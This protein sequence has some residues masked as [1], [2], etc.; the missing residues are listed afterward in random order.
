[1]SAAGGAARVGDPAGEADVAV[2]PAEARRELLT[3]LRRRPGWTA[4]AATAL[5]AS[6]VAAIPQATLLAGALDG[7]FLRGRDLA[8]LSVPLVLLLAVVALRAVAEGAGAHA[9]ARAAS[10]VTT[11]LRAELTEGLLALG[12]AYLE[13]RRTGELGNDVLEGTERVGPVVARFLPQ[14]IVCAV[15]PVAVALFVLSLDPLSGMILLL[16]GP[17]IPLF[18]W[19]LGGLA[20]KR[21]ERQWRALGLLSAQ[22]LDALKGLETLR[23]FGRAREH[24][25]ALA[26]VG[27]R[28]RRTT[29]DVLRAAFLSGFALELLAMLGTAM[30][31]VSVGLRL[32]TG[33]IAFQVAL[34]ALLLAPEF[35]LPFRRLGAHH[36]AGMEG[37]AALRDV[38]GHLRRAAATHRGA[39][40]D[41]GPPAPSSSGE[42]R[43]DAAGAA[44]PGSRTPAPRVRL[45]DIWA[46]YPGREEPA[47]RGVSLELAAGGMTALVGPSGAGKSSVARVLIG[48]LEPECG[49]IL[50]DG[51]VLEPAHGGAW[52]ARLALV[53]QQPHLFAGSVLANLRLARP[54]ASIDEVVAAARLAEA[55]GFIRRLPGG[56]AAP[57]GEDGADL[58]GGERHR[59]AI[60]R[61]FLGDADVVVLDEMSAYLDA[62]T[63]AA[64]TRAVRRLAARS[65]LLVIA[66]RLETVRRARH[67]VVMHHGEVVQEGTYATLLA[68]PGAFAD[69][70]GRARAQCAA[71]G[72]P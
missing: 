21:A 28:Y 8:T 29:M 44:G 19:L 65:A 5:T 41:D 57:L 1:M 39:R 45:V 16:T 17:L 67:I 6:G 60:A 15:A 70:A 69:L 33:G 59:L 48:T 23:L 66:H 12:P 32:A 56:Y 42:P 55:D 49:R 11:A 4:L 7:A 68:S 53:P 34:T 2:G 18:M 47:L 20:E 36:H 63:E 51:A 35:Y 46:R 10:E 71:T 58:S 14:V 24:E 31:A 72:A 40:S 27:E 9:G 38:L 22:A 50:V 30:V 54:G 64:L 61:A 37:V 3:R 52:R 26:R 25:R 13:R 62:A 43:P